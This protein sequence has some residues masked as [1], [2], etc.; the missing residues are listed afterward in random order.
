SGAESR[1]L[2]GSR[3]LQIYWESTRPACANSRDRAWKRPRPRATRRHDICPARTWRSTAGNCT[4]HCGRVEDERLPIGM[5]ALTRVGVLEQMG[6]V[7][8]GKAVPVGREVRRHPVENDGNAVLMQIVHE[9]HE[10]LRRAVT[11]RRRK[12][13]GGLISPGTVEGMLHDR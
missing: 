10:I 11:R 3:V 5:E 6:A 9:V 1:W 7:E 13:A 4:L 12:V 8:E 2:P